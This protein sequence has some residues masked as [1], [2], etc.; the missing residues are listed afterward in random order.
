MNNRQAMSAVSPDSAI[1]TAASFITNT[2]WRDY[3]GESTMSYL[4]QMAALAVQNFVSA[5][6]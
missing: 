3:G 2:N 4:T 1:N 5:A 6:E